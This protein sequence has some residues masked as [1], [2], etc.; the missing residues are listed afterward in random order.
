MTTR[1]KSR[2]RTRSP[3][4]RVIGG[5][6]TAGVQWNLCWV[7][8]FCPCPVFSLNIFC[9]RKQIY[10][11]KRRVILILPG[12]GQSPE[13]SRLNCRRAEL[14]CL[15]ERNE[16]VIKWTTIVSNCN[17]LQYLELGVSFWGRYFDPGENYIMTSF[18]FMKVIK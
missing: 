1:Q 16:L 8:G 7:S 9:G 4:V 5:V 18:T 2:I 17:G 11:P 13:A 10:F 3:S 6:H 15:A 14:H 12:N